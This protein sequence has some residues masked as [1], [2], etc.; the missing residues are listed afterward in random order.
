MSFDLGKNYF[1][2]NNYYTNHL[3]KNFSIATR[4]DSSDCVTNYNAGSKSCF[5]K[6][7]NEFT[8]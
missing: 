2:I 3:K 7:C 4:E 1:E 5:A 6:S 8:L